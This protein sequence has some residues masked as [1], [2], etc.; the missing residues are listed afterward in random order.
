MAMGEGSSP[1]PPP[2]WL[3][4]EL[5]TR[6]ASAVVLGLATLFVTYHGGWLF[7]LLWLAAGIAVLVEWINTT[8]VEAG[9]PIKVALGMALAL[10]S[11][12]Y[13]AEAQVSTLAWAAA[14]ALLAGTVLARN[15][16]DRFWT[17]AGLAYAA[18]IVLVPPVVR[19]RPDLGLT[20]VL[21]MFA[22]VWTTDVAAYFTGR[23][24]GGP[25]LWQRVSPK[26]TWSG[27]VGGLAGA[28]L[29]GLAVAAVAAAWGWTPPAG[30]LAVALASAVASVASQMGDL[31]ESALKRRF[32]AKDSGHLIPGHGGAM[33]RLDGFWAVCVLVGLALFLHRWPG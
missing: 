24:F 25:K 33:D 4:T 23:H 29:C 7:A 3:A 14:A 15:G 2:R 17:A 28:V 19:D 18:V 31:A 9:L 13:L 20:G 5:G 22:V 12:L 16:R 1:A 6:F 27:F 30:L 21:W 8:R 26:K 10:L 32:D 11:G